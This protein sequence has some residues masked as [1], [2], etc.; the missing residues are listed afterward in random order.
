MKK[1]N[2]KPAIEIQ[3]P[4]QKVECHV[5]KDYT[6]M[7]DFYLKNNREISYSSLWRHLKMSYESVDHLSLSGYLKSKGYSKQSVLRADGVNVKLWLK[8]PK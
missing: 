4:N 8:S 6:K 2:F 3:S 1:K 5:T 7:I